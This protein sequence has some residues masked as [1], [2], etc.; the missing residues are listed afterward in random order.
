MLSSLDIRSTSSVSSSVGRSW[1]LG[2]RKVSN[3]HFS[4]SFMACVLGFCF[5]VEEVASHGYRLGRVDGSSR[6]CEESGVGIGIGIG[7]V[8]DRSSVVLWEVAAR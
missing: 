7:I 4:W 5:G 6:W 8:S 1:Y 2:V 3:K